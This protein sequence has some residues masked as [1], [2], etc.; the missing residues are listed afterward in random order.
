M[1]PLKKSILRSKYWWR[2]T[3]DA[4]YTWGVKWCRT[5]FRLSADELRE[6]QMQRLHEQLARFRERGLCDDS[7]YSGLAENRDGANLDSLPV[8][9]KRALQQ[10][11]PLLAEKYAESCGVYAN[12]TGGSTGEPVQYFRSRLLDRRG[13]GASSEMQRVMGWQP[14]MQR[15]CLWGSERDIGQAE[16][17]EGWLS[18]LLGDKTLI[19]AY[20]PGETEFRRFVDA[21]K[22]HRNCAVYGFTS[23]LT[24]CARMM[25]DRGWEL[26]AGQVGAAWSGAETLSLTQRNLF[27]QAFG[28]PIRDHY[29]SRECSS[30]AAECEEGTR[31][32]NPRYI[33]EVVDP[34]GKAV[35]PAERTGLLLVTDLLNDVTPL[36]RYEIGD[37]GAIAWRD[38]PCGRSGPC[39]TELAGRIAE[40]F[41]LS[42]G[43][44]VS[45]LFFNH[46]FK[47]FPGV[48]QFQVLRRS[49]NLFD[50][51]FMGSELSDEQSARVL[52]AATRILE[53][54]QVQLKRVEQLDRSTSGK[55]IQYRDLRQSGEQPR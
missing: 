29:G 38:C 5:G 20:A 33:V 44:K 15:V 48:H 50:V 22:L 27:R 55:L 49:D 52:E 4:A 10:L 13:A 28:I 30:I 2:R 24:E 23:L 40:M 42:S 26:E 19:G 21:V 8:L 18:R 53:G 32:I 47:E 9:D 17:E 45:A 51:H 6:R 31:H 41:V 12:A 3:F 16:Q 46:L 35:L 1:R 43:T 7:A 14:G 54:A 37:L 39:F 36:I 25:I 34:E 11:Y